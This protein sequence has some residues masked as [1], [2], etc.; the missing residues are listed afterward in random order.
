MGE[1]LAP[2]MS[3]TDEELST[4]REI[5]KMEKPKGKPTPDQ[6][7]KMKLDKALRNDFLTVVSE[8]LSYGPD[9]KKQ[10]ERELEAAVLEGAGEEAVIN[11]FL[12]PPPGTRDFYPKEK[13]IQN[14]LF[15]EFRAVAR[16]F[17][18]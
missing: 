6:Q 18:F 11:P 8:R 1:P 14:W 13:R 5:P 4:W 17:G 2:S 9:Q 7:K 16:Q 15:G 10:L 12:N 3:F